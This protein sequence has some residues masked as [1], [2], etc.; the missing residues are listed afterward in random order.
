ML[1]ALASA[2]LLAV[3][4]KI[5]QEIAPFPFLWVL[6]LT[7]YLIAFI[8]CFEYPNAYHR[9]IVLP[10]AA[11]ATLAAGYVIAWRWTVPLP[12]Q[13]I[14]YAA[15]LLLCCLFC[16]GE[17][18]RRRPAARHLTRYYLIVALG[19]VLGAVL[20]TLVAPVVFKQFLELHVCILTTWLVAMGILLL[21]PT[22]AMRG[23]RLPILWLLAAIALPCL[24]MM[25]YW[26]MSLEANHRIYASRS[27]YGVMEVTEDRGADARQVHRE[28]THNGTTHGV[29][30]MHDE[31][32]RKPTSYYNEESGV[33]L[34]MRKFRVDQPRRVG[35]VGLGAG[36]L[37]AYGKA[38]D[39]FVFYELDPDVVDVARSM[40]TFLKDTPANV[41]M[42]LGDA[43]LSMARQEPQK[44]DILVLDAFSGDAVPVHL[45]TVEAFDLYRKHL[46]PDGVIAVHLSNRHLYLLLPGVNV[47]T[48]AG[49]D[50]RIYRT[51]PKETPYASEWMLATDDQAFVEAMKSEPALLRAKAP[52]MQ[53]WTDDHA[54][55]FPVMRKIIN[56]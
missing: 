50:A 13:V 52:F 42:V 22:S 35:V 21:D 56:R 7:L 44:F 38:G 17:T 49:F 46:T 15:T 25:L 54:P 20:V 29:Q 24:A 10:L 36:T 55:L 23:F 39:T 8:V 4:N 9:G 40:F 43:R 30:F 27:F 12:I 18:V 41:E 14:I 37:A 53:P 2:L 51:Y 5:C 19:G 32:R 1:T 31:F 48:H 28:L 3:T 33:G 11:L 45:M 47:A 34:A 16:L 26:E 6:P